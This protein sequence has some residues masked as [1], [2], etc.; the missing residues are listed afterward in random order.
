[1]ALNNKSYNRHTA[2]LSTMQLDLLD[3][4]QNPLTL[5]QKQ[6]ETVRAVIVEKEVILK[7]V[8]K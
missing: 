8:E 3:Y 1:M 5:K 2:P 4:Y 6:Y 7:L